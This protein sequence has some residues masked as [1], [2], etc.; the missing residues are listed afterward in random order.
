MLDLD[1]RDVGDP[2][3]DV[4]V[5]FDVAPHDLLELDIGAR[6]VRV[7][8]LG[9]VLNDRV[10]LVETLVSSDFKTLVS[11]SVAKRNELERAST[12]T[13]ADFWYKLP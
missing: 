5:V 1:R 4:L 6:T 12:L 7:D 2:D 9:E 10:R 13:F 11:I 3:D 8:L